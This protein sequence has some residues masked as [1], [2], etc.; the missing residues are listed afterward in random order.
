MVGFELCSADERTRIPP[1]HS[2]HSTERTVVHSTHECAE[3]SVVHST[4]AC[5]ERTVAGAGTCGDLLH[6][7][8]GY[9]E[10]A[11]Y[12]SL[13]QHSRAVHEQTVQLPR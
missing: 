5:A 11:A 1:G 13:S 12:T 3:H 8:A 10:Q 6:D 9:R 4:H 2:L 7:I